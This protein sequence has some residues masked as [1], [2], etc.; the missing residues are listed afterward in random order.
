MLGHGCGACFTIFF[1]KGT[2][3]GGG[4]LVK[5]L[6]LTPCA[7]HVR[8]CGDRV[9]QTLVEPL[10]AILTEPEQGPIRLRLVCSSL[11]R[12]LAPSR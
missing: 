10:Y 5:K 12:T 8:P 11:L 6:L 1:V 7:A 3:L 2:A 4:G 9:P